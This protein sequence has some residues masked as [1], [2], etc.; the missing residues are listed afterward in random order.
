VKIAKKKAEEV[1]E[2]EA[3]VAEVEA[4]KM[5]V[6]EAE[7][8]AEAEESVSDTE[9]NAGDET[10]AV[11]EDEPA[12]DAESDISLTHEAV[13]K[14]KA[15]AKKLPTYI[16]AGETS[17]ERDRRT[18]FVGNIDLAVTRNKVSSEARRRWDYTDIPVVAERAARAPADV[19]AVGQNRVCA[20]P[21]G[22]LCDAD[23]GAAGRGREGGEP[24]R[25]ARKGARGA[26]ARDAGRG[27]HGGGAWQPA[28][29][30]RGGGQ[31][32]ELPGLEGQA[33]GCVH[34]GRGE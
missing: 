32:E 29:R 15:K 31:V 27:Q 13:K 10:L 2:V 23:G 11:D 21:L 14:A 8:E 34:Q 20:L 24:A 25:Q 7:A 5:D 16:P 3:E 19:C 28:R 12:S 26:E 4:E 30:G 18:V 33:Q 9:E 17:E 6:E 22:G 1:K